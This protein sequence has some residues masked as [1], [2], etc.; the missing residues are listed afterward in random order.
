MNVAKMFKLLA[1]MDKGQL[2][3][4]YYSYNFSVNLKLFLIESWICFILFCLAF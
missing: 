4:Q 2:S 3:F 1:N